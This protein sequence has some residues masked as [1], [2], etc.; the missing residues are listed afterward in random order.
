MLSGNAHGK[1]LPCMEQEELESVS[2]SVI[3]CTSKHR[4]LHL[5]YLGLQ[6]LFLIMI[7]TV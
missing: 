1:V 3:D 6:E 2:L 5:V 4:R 7:L